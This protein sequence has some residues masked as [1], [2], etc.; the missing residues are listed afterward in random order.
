MSN[1]TKKPL[2]QLMGERGFKLVDIRKTEK[3]K[4][5]FRF[6]GGNII[7]EVIANGIYKFI[8]TNIDMFGFVDTGYIPHIADDE[9]FNKN[10]LR[11]HQTIKPLMENNLYE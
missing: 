1:K 11:F 8:Y 6:T 2:T 10:L 3:N 7:V 4:Y 5:C 9:S